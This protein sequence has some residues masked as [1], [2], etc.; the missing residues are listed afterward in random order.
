MFVSKLH[1]DT[2]WTSGAVVHTGEA[3]NDVSFVQKQ[4]RGVSKSS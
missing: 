1:K 2:V 3:K 4:L